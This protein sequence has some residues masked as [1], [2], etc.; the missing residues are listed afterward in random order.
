M[1]QIDPLYLLNEALREPRHYFA[2]LEA[3]GGGRRTLTEIAGVTGLERTNLPKYLN[4]LCS[5]GIVERRTPLEPGRQ[6]GQRREGNN[7]QQRGIYVISDPYL[8]FYFRF[9]VPHQAELQQGQVDRVWQAIEGELPAFVGSTVFEEL[10]RAWVQTRGARGD[11]PFRPTE[12]G[13]YWDRHTQV[14]VVA[15]SA[16]EQALLL[17]EARYTSR[18]IGS[19]V[20]A[21]LSEKATRLTPP[22][23]R[24]HLA[25]FAR[26]GFTENLQEE[27]GRKNV[28]LVDQEQ[29]TTP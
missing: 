25:L 16:S 22:G 5:L 14:D 19:D 12:V 24:A 15:V 27:A 2:V 10:C 8:R 7:T 20:L 3:I 1:F 23:W 18:P 26:S 9:I 4:T 28:F 21:E 17:G 6:S 29:V 11:L 13:S